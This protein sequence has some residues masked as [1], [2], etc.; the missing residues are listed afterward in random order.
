MKDK[1]FLQWIYNRLE[2]YFEVD[3][4]ADYMSKLRAVIKAT[5]PKQLTP[6]ISF[7]QDRDVDSKIHRAALKVLKSPNSSKAAK[8]ARG[9]ALTQR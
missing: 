7:D 5:D 9:S 6:N 3:A 4:R 8:T 2:I 1:E